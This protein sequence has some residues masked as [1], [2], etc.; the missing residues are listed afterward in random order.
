MRIIDLFC[1]ISSHYLVIIEP[2]FH[3]SR[4]LEV[5]HVIISL[6][7]ALPKISV[8][9]SEFFGRGGNFRASYGV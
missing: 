9:V 4:E 5:N 8:P 7:V 2:K 6:E 3:H 1:D